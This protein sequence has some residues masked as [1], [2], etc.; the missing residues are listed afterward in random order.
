M[1]THKKTRRFPTCEQCGSRYKKIDKHIISVYHLMNVDKKIDCKLCDK[2]FTMV[3]SFRSHMYW[4]HSK[5]TQEP[6][7]EPQQ[8]E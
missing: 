6:Q 8:Q 7:P 1:E 2:T 5:R 3:T 4:K